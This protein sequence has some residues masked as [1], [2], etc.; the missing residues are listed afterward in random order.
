MTT[1]HQTIED[2]LESKHEEPVCAYIYDLEKL[3]S[4]AGKLKQSLPSF[5]R[6]YYAVKANPDQRILETLEPVMDGFEVASAGEMDKVEE[7]SGK[8]MI[9][10]G[11]GKKDSEIAAA[12]DTN[13]EYINVESFHEL[14]RLLYIAEQMNRTV[15]ILIRVNLRTNVSESHL[16]MAGVPSQF[17]VD[18]WE[19]PKFIEQAVQSP[20]ISIE[21]FHFHAMSNNLDVEA[22]LRFVEAAVAKTEDWC[23]AYGLQASIVD[24]GGGIGINYWNPEEPFAWDRLAEG[25]AALE[26]KGFTLIIELG[27]Y[28]TAGCG[29][30]AAEVLDVKTNHGYHYAVLRGGSH[31][32]RLPAAW[33]MSHPFR[34]FPKEEWR[35]P[36]GRP[37]ISESKVTMAGE[38]CT[39]NDVLV[40]QE[41][42]GRLRAGDVVLF[43]YAGAY[44]WTISHHDF[45]SH[46]HPE[47]VYVG[48]GS[49]SR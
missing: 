7:I 33:K 5:C 10:G 27:R 25:I 9:F 43:E 20:F 13:I 35:Y 30:Y 14:N 42:V 47:M 37:G 32:L 3:Q 39:P 40:R 49:L 2:Y 16:R 24:V 11:P 31:H 34:V 21:G 18:E 36:F 1:E 41:Y 15:P 17:G 44:A 29:T 6:L 45:L 48:T 46:P 12:L 38:L 28:M 23:A 22:H 19:I 4:H 8:S 26:Q